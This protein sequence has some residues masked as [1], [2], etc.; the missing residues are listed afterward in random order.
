[1]LSFWRCHSE[2]NAV[3]LNTM[4]SFWRQCCHSEDNAVI[5]RVAK[6]LRDTSLYYIS[7]SMT[8]NISGQDHLWFYQTQRV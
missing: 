8:D 3:I 4:L 1:M 7:F 2:D 6:N 5:L